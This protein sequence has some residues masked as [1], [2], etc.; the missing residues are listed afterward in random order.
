MGMNFKNDFELKLQ[1]KLEKGG[2]KTTTEFARGITTLYMQ[3]VVKGKPVGVPA[4]LPSPAQSGAPAPVGPAPPIPYNKREKIFYNTVRAYFVA[5]EISQGKGAIQ[6]L[7][8]DLQNLIAL[9]IKLKQEAQQ[10]I[11]RIKQV[12]E[13]IK[14]LREE[15]KAI[16]PAVQ[17][18][19]ATQK[20][21]FVDLKKSVE[22]FTERLGSLTS[23]QVGQAATDGVNS[24]FKRE[25]T[26][27]A[28][29][30]DFKFDLKT[31]KSSI[32]NTVAIL[33]ESSSLLSKYE[34]DFSSTANI[35][36]Y[37]WKK[38][39]AFF[40]G[41]FELLGAFVDPMTFASYFRQ[42]LLIPEAKRIGRIMLRIINK[43]QNLKREKAKLMQSINENYH[44]LETK[45]KKKIE[46]TQQKIQEKADKLLGT[47]GESSLGKQLASAA[48]WARTELKR[49]QE[50]IAFTYKVIKYFFD[51]LNEGVAITEKALL[52]VDSVK[53]YFN[54]TI[55]EDILQKTK[56]KIAAIK[57]RLSSADT[58]SPIEIN[59]IFKQFQITQEPIKLMIESVLKANKLLAPEMLE[60]LKRP[61]TKL[62]AILKSLDRLL[63]YDLINF[64]DKI[65]HPPTRERKRARKNRARP[66]IDEESPIKERKRNGLAILEKLKDVFR[67][68]SYCTQVIQKK[69]QKLQDDAIKKLKK[70]Q[71]E[72]TEYIST[73]TNF[74]ATKKKIDN[75]KRSIDQ[76]KA[77]IEEDTKKAVKV[78][79]S[80]VLFA[81][82]L[83]SS[84][85]IIDRVVPSRSEGLPNYS[86]SANE[87]D[88]L[89]FYRYFGQWRI[90]ENDDDKTRTDIANNTRKLKRKLKDFKV[91]ELIFQFFTEVLKEV[92]ESGFNNF[93]KE[94][95]K[96]QSEKLKENVTS[97]WTSAA[98]SLTRFFESPPKTISELATFPLDIIGLLDLN[99]DILKGENRFLTK[100]KAK[101]KGLADKIPADTEDPTLLF[102]KRQLE[103]GVGFL[104]MA[105]KLISDFVKAVIKFIREEL[106]DPA[107]NKVKGW[108]DQYKT[109]FENNQKERI[110]K[111]FDS[112]ARKKI[113]LATASAIF[114]LAGRLFW[115]AFN[116]QNP[117]GTT[118]IVL[119]VGPFKPMIP[120]EVNGSAGFAQQLSQGFEL[121]VMAM[122]GLTIPNPSFAI[123]PVPF[124]GYS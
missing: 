62:T 14:Q 74:D 75:K 67:L 25:L 70:I 1:T 83:Q 19:I 11:D 27:I 7:T 37:I 10:N 21:T 123:P 110:D 13:E 32:Q 87:K 54:K 101:I 4:T 73:V 117:A 104:T 6:F 20:K 71:N 86:I 122:T 39:Q 124:Q 80:A 106:I 18:F 94:T 33:N 100:T 114:G 120:E 105:I 77:D 99:V 64:L 55:K 53:Q 28:S 72:V 40:S 84:Y 66:A 3:T 43:N 82:M 81:K 116:W 91:Y 109:K 30:Q 41:V 79:K 118:F 112:E 121:Q 45:V 24:A 9:G 92:K 78:A 59:A 42:L 12:D 57:T 23:D 103:K 8:R 38:L 97:E 95:L 31:L 56:D 26:L 89:D 68:L 65:E 22:G 29:I 113:D 47:L 60:A 69:I 49:V 44:E 96:E 46:N 5:K 35:R 108:I 51:L 88:I 2:Y 52:I 85:R 61:T 119:N 36:I 93:I 63:G 90:L 34:N 48:K 15:I 115:T 98:D 50:D 107:L 111:R 76:Q 102:F 17:E 16:G 58:T